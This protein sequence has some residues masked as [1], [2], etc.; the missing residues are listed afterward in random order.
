MKL[1][2]R[3]FK[4]GVAIVF[5]LFIAELLKLPSPV[6][7]GI[8]AIFAIQPSIYRSYQTIVEQVQAN[9]IG[10]TIAVLFGLLFG[11]HVVAIGIAVIIAIGLMLKFKLEKS[12]SLALVSVVAIM[13]FQGEDFLTFGLIRFVTILVGVL[14]AFVVNLV[15]LPP[16]Y[17]IKLFRKIYILQDDIIRW[18]RLA[19]RQ[20]SEHTSTKGALSKFKSRMLRVDTLYDLYKEERNYFKNKKYVKA[21]KLVVYRQMILTSKKSLELLQRLHNHE[22]EL[23]KLPTQFHLMIQERLDSL[24]TYHEQ[25]LLKYTG[26]LKPEHSEWSTSIDYVQRNELMEI[27]I[28]QVNFAREEGDTEFSS[29]HL[30]YILSRIL[31]YEENLEHLDTLIV[32]YQSYHGHEINVEFEEEF[33]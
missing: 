25:L 33:I 14:A 3:V 12:L 31:D 29:Y 10:A 30:L 16:K 19:V 8:A 9:I 28:K 15:F 27:F 20:A 18:T 32:S 7:A 22:N 23:A 1:G 2:A 21:R 6:F 17:E 26:K 4:T 11:H 24:L 5:A 13:E